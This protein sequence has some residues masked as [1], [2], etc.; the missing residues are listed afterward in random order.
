MQRAMQFSSPS[1]QYTS[2]E[3]I[4][5]AGAMM[6]GLSSARARRSIPGCDPFRDDVVLIQPKKLSIDA[7]SMMVACGLAMRRFD[8][9]PHQPVALAQSAPQATICRFFFILMGMVAG[10][11]RVH[12]PAGARILHAHFQPDGTQIQGREHQA[13]QANQEMQEK[14]EIQVQNLHATRFRASKAPRNRKVYSSI[15]WRNIVNL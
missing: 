8:R 12:R 10:F 14:D 6:P 9:D 5:L 7:P 11:S 15:L 3:H 4:L 1:T 2:V 13:R